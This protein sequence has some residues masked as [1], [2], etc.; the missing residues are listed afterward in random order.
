MN[1]IATRPVREKSPWTVAFENRKHLGDFSTPAWKQAYGII[2]KDFSRFEILDCPNKAGLTIDCGHARIKNQAI[3]IEGNTLMVHISDVASFIPK[4]SPLDVEMQSRV[5]SIQNSRILPF[6]L[7]K[8]QFSLEQNQKTKCLTFQWA[9]DEYGE[10]NQLRRK[11]YHSNVEVPISISFEQADGILEDPLHKYHPVIRSLKSIGEHLVDLRIRNE[12]TFTRERKKTW[13]EK[14]GQWIFTDY[15][16]GSQS[17]NDWIMQEVMILVNYTVASLLDQLGI[18]G[19]YTDPYRSPNGIRYCQATAPMHNLEDL[20]NQRILLALL[21]LGKIPIPYT[22]EEMEEIKTKT[23][24][25]YFA[26][27]SG[28]KK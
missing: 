18:H 9:F 23:N 20:V 7:A 8:E 1:D 4:D 13:V 14:N 6:R 2:N 10:I 3:G 11:I 26:R 28:G 16:D 22:L 5:I 24:R 27:S 25:M 15:I 21:S 19:C 17:P 12:W